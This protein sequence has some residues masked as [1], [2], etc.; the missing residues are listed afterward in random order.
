[1]LPIQ[2]TG[3]M[4]GAII[5]ILCLNE[6]KKQQIDSDGAQNSKKCDMTQLQRE[7]DV[8]RLRLVSKRR[9]D[10]PSY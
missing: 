7:C 8:F 6:H 2:T 10:A 9:A 5:S 1:M 4:L 3:L